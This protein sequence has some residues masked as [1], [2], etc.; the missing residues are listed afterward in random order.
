M[1][2]LE[3]AVAALD[4]EVLEPSFALDL[5][6][7]FSKVEK[8]GAAGKALAAERVAS[9]GAWR[10]EGDRTAAHFIARTT[11]DSVGAS[12]TAIETAR[13]LNELPKTQE[14]FRSGELTQAQAA[15][16]ASAASV[17]PKAEKMLLELAKTEGIGAL[18]QEAQRV[19]AASCSDEMA[20]AERL[21]KARYLRS[22]TDTDGAFRLD[23][24]LAPV[25]GAEVRAMLDV[26][27]Q[28]QF[29]AARRQR[30]KESFEALDADALWEM[31]RIAREGKAH[32]KGHKAVIN[33][34][35]DHRSLKRGHTVNG[36]V[37]E[38]A[39]VGPISVAEAKALMSDAVLK[40]LVTKGRDVIAVAND[41]VSVTAGKKTALVEMQPECIIDGCHEKSRLETDHVIPRYPDGTNELS[42]L[43]RMCQHHHHLKT[44]KGFKLV[45]AKD[46]WRLIPP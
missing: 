21:H 45:K 17:A 2:L 38:V 18:K 31:A 33:V 40:V 27:K 46:K 43:V 42:N 24:R 4:P 13:R 29:E 1:A 28:G 11:G 9:T 39:G 3:K 44:Y 8:L 36:E 20:R 7:E 32:A 5:V 37:C 16:I 26:L 22:W 30:R 15:E 10:I 12:V 14:A 25:A 41:G 23:A 35:V 34:R 6:K 19:V